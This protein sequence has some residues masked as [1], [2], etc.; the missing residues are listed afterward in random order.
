MGERKVSMGA[1]QYVLCKM[2]PLKVDLMDSF[3]CGVRLSTEINV[4]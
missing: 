1:I 3:L 2:N 4:C